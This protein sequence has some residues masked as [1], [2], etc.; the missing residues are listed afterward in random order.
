MS[1]SL[2]HLALECKLIRMKRFI[3]IMILFRA[4]DRKWLEPYE[5]VVEFK[6]RIGELKSTEVT[7]ILVDE[8]RIGLFSI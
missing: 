2:E 6:K 4:I 1:F 5:G 8:F 3:K 7:T